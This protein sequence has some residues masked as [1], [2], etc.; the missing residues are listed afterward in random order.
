VISTSALPP[1]LAAMSS[2][3]R[4]MRAWI[5]S[6]IFASSERIV[7]SISTSSG[8]MLFRTPPWIAPTVTI[9]GASDESTWRLGIVCSPRTICDAIT[10]GSTPSHG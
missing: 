7:P 9:D 3:V 4:L 1:P 10:I 6:R 8:M 5:S 2:A